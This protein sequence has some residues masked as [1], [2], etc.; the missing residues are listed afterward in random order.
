MKQVLVAIVGPAVLHVVSCSARVPAEEHLCYGR[1]HEAMVA[2]I[3]SPVR[4]VQ[5]DLSRF[6]TLR[7]GVV[8]PASH[9]ILIAVTS[10]MSPRESFILITKNKKT[11]D[12]VTKKSLHHFEN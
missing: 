11:P 7:P 8:T 9:V 1:I 3:G 12:E 5:R 10:V 4:L 2:S 6:E